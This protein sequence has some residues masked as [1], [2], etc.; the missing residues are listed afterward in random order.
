MCG[1][2]AIIPGTAAGYG[3]EAAMSF[4]PDQPPSGWVAIGGDMAAAMCGSAAAGGSEIHPVLGLGLQRIDDDTDSL[5]TGI[6]S[7]SIK[8]K[9]AAALRNLQPQRRIQVRLDR[10]EG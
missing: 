6:L 10:D 2:Q 3:L 7:T 1:R 9:E 4:G 8:Q 5:A